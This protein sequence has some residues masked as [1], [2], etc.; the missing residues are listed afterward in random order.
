M[1][2]YFGD[3]SWSMEFFGKT[4]TFVN[5]STNFAIFDT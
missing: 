5:E 1:T 3:I 2:I 4:E